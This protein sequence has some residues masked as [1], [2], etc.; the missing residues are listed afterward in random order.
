MDISINHYPLFMDTVYGH[1]QSQPMHTACVFQSRGIET[2]VHLSYQ[3]LN[4][5]VSER[6]QLL[7]ALG[8]QGKSVALIYP[9]GLDFIVN[10]LACLSAGVIA[11]PLNVTRNAQQFERTINIF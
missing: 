8:Y 11:V 7:L 1:M 4:V 3:A 5:K 9:S 2:A 10:F 6:T